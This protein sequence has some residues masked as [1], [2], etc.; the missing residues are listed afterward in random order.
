MEP[1]AGSYVLNII[2]GVAAWLLKQAF[3]ELKE[4]HKNLSR[5]YDNILEE[6]GDVKDKYFKKEDFTEFKRELWT[7]FDRFEDD[8]K[9]QLAE[10]RK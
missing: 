5:K 4:E 10:I 7:R 6:V 1:I 9:N 3:Q 8:V 2:L